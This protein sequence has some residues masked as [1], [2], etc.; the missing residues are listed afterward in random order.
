MKD[1]TIVGTDHGQ[2]CIITKEEFEI[3]NN[4][5]AQVSIDLIDLSAEISKLI[6]D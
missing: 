2:L 5:M 6:K 1:G 4:Q 3:Y